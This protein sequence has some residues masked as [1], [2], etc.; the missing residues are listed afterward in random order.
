MGTTA[1]ANNGIWAGQLGGRRAISILVTPHPSDP[2][3]TY[4]VQ[5][6]G[7]GRTPFSRSAD[8]LAVLAHLF[9]TIP[10]LRERPEKAC[11][12]T[13]VAETFILIGNLEAIP[14]PSRAMSFIGGRQRHSA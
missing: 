14:P 7:A 4:E 2:D 8:G 1:R 10:V 5:L 12:K 11:V 9:V 6:K 3:T 13:R